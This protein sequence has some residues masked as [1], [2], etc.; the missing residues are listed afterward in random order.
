M[1]DT[2]TLAKMY[3]DA[4][5]TS[6]YGLNTTRRR[7]LGAVLGLWSSGALGMS[8]PRKNKRSLV[9]YALDTVTI[10]WRAAQLRQMQDAFRLYPEID[11]IYTDSQGETANQIADIEDLI[12]RGVDVLLVSPRDSRALAPVIGQ[13]Y[14]AG[15][16]VVLV[17]RRILG[18]DFTTFVAPDD[19]AIGR[20]AA[21][22]IASA[23]R[24]K[25][26][27]L[28]LQGVPSTTT[29]IA[30]SQSFEQELKRWPGIRIA[31][32]KVANYLRGEAVMAV[33]ETIQQG[34]AFDAIYAQS[35]GMASGARLALTKAGIDPRSKVIVGIDYSREAREAIQ[36][37]NQSASFVYPTCAT[38]VLGVVRTV[39]AGRRVPRRVTVASQ[40]ITR[41]NVN[42]IPPTY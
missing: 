25:G 18:E 37:G 35:D 3:M 10:E 7:W 15:I 16:P 14:R 23:L 34:V 17:T 39:L 20:D 27:V 40:R 29:A 2:A 5:A 28:V 8:K 41:A 38:E 31:A 9:G 11:F 21:R 26:R 30:R 6:E 32:S 24:G 42:Q 19:A 1:S 33:E 36:A 22:Y 12:A 13:A 4:F